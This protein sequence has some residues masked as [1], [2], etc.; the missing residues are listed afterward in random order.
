MRKKDVGGL[1]AFG[2]TGWG[3][4][5]LI[6]SWRSSSCLEEAVSVC[7]GFVLLVLCVFLCW[8]YDWFSLAQK[9]SHHL[10]VTTV[11]S[12]LLRLSS[13]SG[14]GLQE[15]LFEDSGILSSLWC[16]EE[17]GEE[18]ELRSHLHFSFSC[19]G[20]SV[21]QTCTVVKVDG[22]FFPVDVAR[23][24]LRATLLFPQEHSLTTLTS[25]L[26]CWFLS[27][28]ICALEFACLLASW[29]LSVGDSHLLAVIL[30]W[31]PV[32]YPPSFNLCWA[33]ANQS[34]SCLFPLCVSP[35][36]CLYCLALW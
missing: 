17:E 25:S 8:V 9:K 26:S 18:V 23:I 29:E 13:L 24:H 20:G 1:A 3:I 11:A 33:F 21:F 14:I 27:S 5:N 12:W 22:G 19:V 35:S 10:W 2:L 15:S 36:L 6:W 4:C 28:F 16:E 32:P 31:V 30:G 34:H 7:F